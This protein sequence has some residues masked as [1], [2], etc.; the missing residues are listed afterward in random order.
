MNKKENSE[1]E[2][3]GIVKKIV[4]RQVSK[5]NEHKPKD[6]TESVYQSINA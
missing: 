2:F 5:E 4:E 6:K 3:W 1:K